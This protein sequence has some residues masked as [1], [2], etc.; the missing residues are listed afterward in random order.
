MKRR[1]T[2]TSCRR[3]DALQWQQ[4]KY[5]Y[6]HTM[7]L[8][9]LTLRV[10]VLPRRHRFGSHR[11]HCVQHRSLWTRQQGSGLSGLE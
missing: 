4:H 9:L 1:R 11:R 3:Q 6:Q 8:T 10:L 5:H 7:R 2:A